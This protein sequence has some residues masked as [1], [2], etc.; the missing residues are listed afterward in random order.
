MKKYLS[1]VL[2]FLMVLSS[3]A[4]AAPV[5]VGTVETTQE[6]A[7]DAAEVAE[8][9]ADL[10]DESQYGRLVYSLDLEPT[11]TDGVF[12]NGGVVNTGWYTY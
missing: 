3:V 12:Y 2:A 5:A 11:R 6:V 7:A 9:T 1:L 10:Q 8:K 4:F